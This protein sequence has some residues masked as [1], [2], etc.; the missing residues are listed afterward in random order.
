[1][2]ADMKV[3]RYLATSSSNSL[4]EV[5]LE[6]VALGYCEHLQINCGHCKQLL[7]LL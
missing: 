2:I 5:I 3:F 6:N 4:H 7:S 1:M